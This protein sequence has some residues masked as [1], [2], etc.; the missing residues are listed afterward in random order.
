[1]RDRD[2]LIF[3]NTILHHFTRKGNWIRPLKLQKLLYFSHA[4]YMISNNGHTAFSELFQK[5]H[6]GPVLKSVYDEF[7]NF[8]AAH[9]DR[10]AVLDAET[11][12]IYRAEK[13]AISASV[14]SVCKRFKTVD[15]MAM[16]E[17]THKVGSPWSLVETHK[18][19]I[20]NDSM[21]RYYTKY[22][23]EIS[24]D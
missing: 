8:G 16:S 1:M 7:K 15:D 19:D 20:S 11:N 4:H 10:Y 22:L 3:V 21:R 18:G 6:Y 17:L 14:S 13:G 12:M 9:I 2:T 23:K 5:W 24:A